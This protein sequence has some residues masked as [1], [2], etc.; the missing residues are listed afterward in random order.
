MSFRILMMLFRMNGKNLCILILVI[1]VIFLLL[2]T[3]K[4]NT[5]RNIREGI[6]S[7]DIEAA[8]NDDP[9]DM[10]PDSGLNADMFGAG[11]YAGYREEDMNNGFRRNESA[12]VATPSNQTPLERSQNINA[13]YSNPHLSVR[14]KHPVL[15]YQ[16]IHDKGINPANIGDP[17]RVPNISGPMGLYGEPSNFVDSL[18]ISKAYFPRRHEVQAAKDGKRIRE[19]YA[20]VG[21]GPFPGKPLNIP[22]PMNTLKGS[23]E[24]YNPDM[25]RFS[26]LAVGTVAT[27]LGNAII[28]ST[29]VQMSANGVPIPGYPGP[30]GGPQGI[31][32]MPRGYGSSETLP[33][34]SPTGG[35]ITEPGANMPYQ[36]RPVISGD[37]FRPYGPNVPVSGVP[38][39]GSVNAYAPFPE[40]NNPWEKAGILTSIG[41]NTKEEILNLYRRPIAPLQDLWEYQVQDKNGFVIKLENIKYIE[42]GDVIP[43]VI[44][45]KGPWKVH[46]FVQ[47]KY[48]WV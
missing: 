1:L 21:T 29:A 34:F 23:N 25:F 39:F 13:Q 4:D 30:P 19:P 36:T 35:V 14:D 43:H 15:A 9:V 37:F 11:P 10:D 12:F 8:L 47:N 17:I 24:Q 40:V 44:G 33:Q 20:D 6:D 42:N 7:Q 2:R 38:F 28:P 18:S 5:G 22:I 41:E 45:K 48:I 26:P 16:F 31:Y 32:N 3:K 27:A 46:D